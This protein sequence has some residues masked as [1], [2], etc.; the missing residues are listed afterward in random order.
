MWRDLFGTQFAVEDGILYLKVTYLTGETAF[1]PPRGEGMSPEKTCGKIIEYCEKNGLTPRLCSVSG[2][3]LTA[4]QEMESWRDAKIETDRA[5][6]DY[7][8]NSED[9]KTLAGRK[10]SGQRNHMN[11]FDKANA[12]WTFERVSE[13]NLAEV[14]EFFVNYSREHIKDYPAYDEG[15]IK[16]IEVID[17]LALYAQVGGILKTSGNIVGAAFGEVVGDTLFVHA[18]KALTEYQGAYQTLVNSFA[19]E[20]ATAG[21]AYI[22]REED[23]GVMGLRTSKLSYHPVMLLDKYV[24][25]LG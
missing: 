7:I 23:D 25:E 10:Y 19:K 11:K 2:S 21:V 3:F 1:A 22:N 5:W 15:N 8:Y 6:S 24:V 20:F 18:E 12:D 9:I 13:S 17:N 4:V 14:R 16:T